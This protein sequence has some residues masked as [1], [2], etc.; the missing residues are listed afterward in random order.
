MLQT[1]RGSS[2]YTLH[3]DEN[4]NPPALVCTGGKTVLHYHLRAFEDLHQMLKAHGDW[5]PLGS[6]DE[7]KPAAESTVEAWVARRTTPLG[8]GTV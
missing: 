2:E 6:A 1:P 4:I 3:R 5:M 8:V 7:H